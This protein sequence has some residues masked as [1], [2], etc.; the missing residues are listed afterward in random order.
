[1]V[2]HGYQCLIMI[3]SAYILTAIEWLMINGCWL[4]MVNDEW[5]LIIVNAD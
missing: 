3:R 1:M 4:I 2:I 5:F